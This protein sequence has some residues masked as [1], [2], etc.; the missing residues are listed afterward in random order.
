MTKAVTILITGST[1]AAVSAVAKR[2]VNT[3]DN[4]AAWANTNHN[5]LIDSI[6]SSTQDVTIAVTKVQLAKDASGNLVVIP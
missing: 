4:I 1:E 5:G 3:T 6:K 2:F